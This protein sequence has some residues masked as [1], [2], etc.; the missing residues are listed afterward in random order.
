MIGIKLPYARTFP[1]SFTGSFFQKLGLG[2]ILHFRSVLGHNWK[3]E[4]SSFFKFYLVCVKYIGRYSVNQVSRLP[5][6][7]SPSVGLIGE[8]FFFR[9]R[10][11]ET[12]MISDDL[13]QPFWAHVAKYIRSYMFDEFWHAIFRWVLTNVPGNVRFELRSERF[14]RRLSK[15][16]EKW[17]NKQTCHLC[18]L[19]F[20]A[21]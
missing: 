16:F 1:E 13:W 4:N 7:I 18:W 10:T 15:F 12:I 9:S 8:M 3:F 2:S 11:F 5:S 17:H 20:Y 21:G 14:L 6:I 19:T